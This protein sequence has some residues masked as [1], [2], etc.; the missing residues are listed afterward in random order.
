[1]ALDA[2]Y[3]LLFVFFTKQTKWITFELVCQ[4]WVHDPRTKS[5]QRNAPLDRGKRKSKTEEKHFKS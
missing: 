3:S 4:T 1:M 2:Y 5:S